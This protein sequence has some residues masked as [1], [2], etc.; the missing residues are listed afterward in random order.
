[1]RRAGRAAAVG[2]QPLGTDGCA[3]VWRLCVMESQLRRGLPKGW[4]PLDCQESPHH[5]WFS[6]SY[7]FS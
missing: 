1:M 2:Q 5:L 3:V 4:V 6:D 7:S